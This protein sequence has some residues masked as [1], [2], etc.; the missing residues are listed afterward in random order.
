MTKNP[1]YNALAAIAYIV[2]IVFVIYGVD[3]T[4][5]NYGTAQFIMPIM[6]LSLFTLSAAV[7]G[8]IFGYHPARLFLENKRDEGIRLFLNTD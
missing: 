3:Q 1:F 2:G 4:E 6:M 8:Y 7:M 5:T